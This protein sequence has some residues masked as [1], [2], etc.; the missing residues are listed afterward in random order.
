MKKARKAKSL[1]DW[2]IPLDDSIWFWNYCCQFMK[3]FFIN[4]FWWR[5]ILRGF[6]AFCEFQT[7]NW[8]RKCTAGEGDEDPEDFQA[9]SPFC[10]TSESLLYPAAGLPGSTSKTFHNFSFQD[11]KKF[12]C[13]YIRSHVTSI[14]KSNVIEPQCLSKSVSMD[15]Y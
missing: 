6:C 14:T 4:L 2:A 11:T 12:S 9:G 1:F 15:L 5:R 10:W 7:K 13:C 3:I 8:R